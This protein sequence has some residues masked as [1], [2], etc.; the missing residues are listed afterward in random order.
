MK[1]LS[2]ALIV[3]A[4][5][6]V[7][8]KEMVTA[9][10]SSADLSARYAFVGGGGNPPPPDVDT[11]AVG[12]SGGQ[13]FT[14][15]VRYFFNKPANSGWLKFDSEAGDVTVDKNAQVRYSQGVFSGKGIVTVSTASGPASFDLSRVSQTSKFSSCE[16]WS[17][18]IGTGDAVTTSDTAPVGCFNLVIGGVSGSPDI[19]LTEKCGTTKEDIY[20][21][22][23]VC[24]R[25][26]TDLQ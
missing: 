1:R 5:S 22:R 9:P 14:V 21:P 8:C 26:T 16:S 25:Y 13:T 10:N 20:D 7:A 3:S 19:Y 17:A 18:P 2:L 23:A 12:S 6:L 15:G 4:V 11:Q 24:G